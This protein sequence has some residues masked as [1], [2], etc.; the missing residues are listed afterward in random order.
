MLG[1]GWGEE[2]EWRNG[3]IGGE[4][5]R[6]RE[7]IERRRNVGRD[8]REGWIEEMKEGK[9]GAEEKKR[10]RENEGRKEG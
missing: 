2:E 8:R 9:G 10:E 5:E 3:G 6:G 4:R 7:I 1:V